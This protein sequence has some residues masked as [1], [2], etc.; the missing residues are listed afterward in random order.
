MSSVMFFNYDTT[1]LCHGFRADFAVTNN[2]LLC[3]NTHKV[4]IQDIL[5]SR[6]R[7]LQSGIWVQEVES[8]WVNKAFAV[9]ILISLG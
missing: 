4:L 7:H 8:R 9:A 3:F 5:Q 1:R 2:T 6:I